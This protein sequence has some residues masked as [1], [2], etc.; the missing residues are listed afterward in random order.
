MAEVKWIKLTT[1]MFEDE[2]I[3]FIESLPEADAILIIW[4]KLLTLAGKCNA[5]GFIFLT[6]KIPYTPEMLSHKFRRPLNT[7]KMALDTLEKLE[8]INFTNNGTINIS[9]W[10]KHQ[11][12]DGLEKIKEQT[13]KRVAKHRE[14]QKQIGSNATCNVTVTQSN[15]T[16][17]DKELDIDIDIDKE[18]E[19][20]E[21]EKEENHPL[22]DYPELKSK[23]GEWLKYKTERRESYKPMGLKSMYTHIRNKLELYPEKSIIDLIDTC[24]ANGYKGIIWDKLQGKEKKTEAETNGSSEYGSM[25]TDII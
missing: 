12:I 9:N 11:N 5:G 3:D 13:R 18:K 1:G 2:K 4:I 6:E 14:N 25:G 7:T 21:K 17:I 16:D 24:M 19:V 8:M 20:K 22:D 10:E 15:A 23:V